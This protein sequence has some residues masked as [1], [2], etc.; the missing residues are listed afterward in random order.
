MGIFDSVK[1][2][3]S[4]AFGGGGSGGGYLD[5]V[6]GIGGALFS[7]YGGMKAEDAAKDQG[8][9]QAKEYERVARANAKLSMFDAEV[10]RLGALSAEAKADYVAGQ[11]YEKA[12]QILATQTTRYAKSGVAVKTGTPLDVERETAKQAASE[13]AMIK[14]NGQTSKQQALAL[15]ERYKMLAEAGLREGNAQASLAQMAGADRAEM[16]QWQNIS[17]LFQN[18]YSLGKDSGWF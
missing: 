11:T 1:D 14:Y 15:A 6:I 5:D 16:Y 12:K 17:G 10:A 4:G 18:T 2:A 3:V 9:A 7:F 13:I 8:K